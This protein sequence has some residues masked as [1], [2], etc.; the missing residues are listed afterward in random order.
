ML[1]TR[2]GSLLMT[3]AYMQKIE[4]KDYV[5][6]KLQQALSAIEMCCERWCIKINEDKTW[7][8]YFSQSRR[9]P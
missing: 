1:Q 8:I 9:P 7:T 5:F 4:K 2:S 6:R 3:P